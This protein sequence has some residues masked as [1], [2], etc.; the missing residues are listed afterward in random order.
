LPGAW[1]SQAE[2]HGRKRTSMMEAW[3]KESGRAKGERAQQGRA[4]AYL[5]E[6][7]ALSPVS[8]KRRKRRTYPVKW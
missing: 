2:N 7:R 8:E 1:K 4:V 6:V 5:S 3:K